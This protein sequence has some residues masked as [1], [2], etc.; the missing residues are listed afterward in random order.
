MAWLDRKELEPHQISNIMEQL[1]IRPRRTTMLGNE[2]PPDPI[3]LYD[4]Q[5][6]KGL[7]G[8]PRGYYLEKKSLFHEEVVRVS[9]GGPMQKLETKWRA[10]ENGPYAEQVDALR[11]LESKMEDRQWGGMI[12]KAGCSF[13]KTATA[14]EL[15]RRFGRKTVI[16]VHKE[17]LLRQWRASIEK[18]LPGAKVGFIQ[19]DRCDFEGV[20][21]AIAMIQSLS[22]DGWKKYPHGVFGEFGLLIG[23]E[24]HRVAAPTWSDVVCHFNAAWR[25]GL[26]ATPKRLDG[27]E[28]VFF[29][30]IGPIVYSARTEAQRPL[31]RKL[32]TA[33]TLKGIEHGSYQ[34]PVGRLNS[35]QIASQLVADKFRTRDIVDQI[36]GA[37]KAG[38][39]ILVVS[40][41]L[42][43]LKDLGEDLG[44]I[45]FDKDFGF[46][47]TIDFYTGQWFTGEKTN[48]KR[49]KPVM[50]KK[51]RTEEDLEKAE[52][53]NV[54]F[55]T[56]QMVAEGLDIQA[57]DVIVFTTPM[58]DI[59]QAVG[60]VRRW[61]EPEPGKCEHYCP[62]RAGK[63]KGKPQP[64]V[65]DVIDE[66]CPTLLPK[67]KRRQGFYR[68]IGTL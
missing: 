21:F 19:Q 63:C 54:I 41:R 13:G 33:S 66:K 49:G 2:G 9:V 65:L 16:L 35:S 25:I 68:S 28:Q 12:L 40:E 15:A 5:P 24:I 20:D 44:T 10:P 56:K 26:T 38:R 1:T 42:Q 53:A 58:S 3:P 48:P 30:H 37:V 31:L 27:A 64:I 62:W 59:E 22:G 67:W 47:P 14:I 51:P 61:C 4:D 34:V 8:V 6:E 17:F 43:Q 39:K 45:L 11:V 50:K 7:I 23:D 57:L 29:K 55:A 36:V 52:R 18:F 60:R 32:Y 46:V